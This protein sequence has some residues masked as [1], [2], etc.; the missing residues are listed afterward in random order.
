MYYQNA[1]WI[2]QPRQ[3]ELPLT[4]A[5]EASGANLRTKLGSWPTAAN[6]VIN[7]YNALRER[8]K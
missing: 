7:L 2:P 8:E 3:P 4:V 6:Q 1:L 5:L